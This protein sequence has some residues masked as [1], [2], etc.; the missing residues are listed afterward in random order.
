[1]NEKTARA[2]MLVKA[3]EEADQHK[4]VLTGDD[5]QFASR[6]AR[7]LAHW[8]AAEQRS[9]STLPDFLYH[10]AEQLL[11]RLAARH[12]MFGSV[13]RG[14]SGMWGA[15]LLL[16]LAA[17]LAGGMAERFGDPHRVDLLSMP[18]LGI[19]A[20]NM[21]A[22]LLLVLWALLPARRAGLR[23]GLANRMALGSGHVPRR[24]PHALAGGVLQFMLDWARLGAPLNLARIARI[25][26]WSAAAFAI[27][28]ILSLYARGIVERYAA[29]WE[30]TFLDPWQV[31]R[32]LS[33]L[34]APAERIFGLEGFTADEVMGLQNWGDARH[35]NGAR[36]VNL[37]AASL[38][39]YVVLPRLVLGAMAAARALWLRR[40]FPLDL[41]QPYFHQLGV[42]A[43]G[44]PGLL[45]VLPYSLTVDEARSKGLDTVAQEM[46]GE[47]ARVRLLPPAAYG[48]EAPALEA[49]EG[50]TN[51]V[52][53]GLAATPEQENHG[54]FLAALGK[55]RK[56]VALLDQSALAARMD[57]SR[58]SERI[59]LWRE[60]CILHGAEPKVVDLLAPAEV[61]GNAA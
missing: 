57:G 31:Y 32:L 41:D 40:R 10:R 20:W 39:L 19:I 28:A 59:E 7:E 29:G 56:L 50:V 24:L 27:G 46:L 53:F 33:L 21:L 30:S 6:T 15:S 58:L 13:T 23:R 16:P 47:Q 22:Y 17:L 3:I 42:S 52:L 44:E 55:G 34:F 2:I 45:R 35:G 51:A 43:G 9:A 37:Y 54:V 4:E 49:G 36:W 12:K 1:M 38:L 11:K 26:H 61:S 14:H 60:F 48:S 8:Q 18:L 25:L 5:R